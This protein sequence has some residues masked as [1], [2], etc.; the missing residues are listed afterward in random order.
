[1]TNKNRSF[2]NL[3]TT[4][5]YALNEFASK[6]PVE[7]AQNAAVEYD[8]SQQMLNVFFIQE[9]YQVKHPSGEIWDSKGEKASLYLSIILLHYLNTADGTPLAGKWI[10]FKELPGG[11]IYID[12]FRKRAIT[13]FLKIFGDSPQQFIE[14][15]SQAGGFRN[16]QLGEYCMVIPVLPRV[17]IAFIL[18]PGD[19]EFSTTANILFDANASS[20]LPTEDYAHLPAI[21][22]K[23]IK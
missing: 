7:I 5:E 14:A 13:P 10:S 9:L 18:H 12:P 19:E 11:Q 21:I 1:M 6:D 4:H 8:P 22:V 16:P 2:M 20:Y 15:A 17:P 3:D 23:S